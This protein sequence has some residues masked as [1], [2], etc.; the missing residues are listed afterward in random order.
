MQSKCLMTHNGWLALLENVANGRL[1]GE[2]VFRDQQ[3]LL[4]ND[5]EWL[6]SR[7]L[8]PWAVLLDL[9][10]ALGPALQWSTCRNKAMPVPLQILTTLGFLATST[11]QRELAYRS[12]ISQP[13]F[14][15]VMPDVLDGIIGL[16]HL[17]IKFP[18]MVGEQ[19]NKKGNLQ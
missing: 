4:A 7:F 11:F 3:D 18:Y 15:R 2:R 10:V 16:L 6:M 1:W 19:A 12:G 5:D 9:C 14:S 17:D 8:F 13:T